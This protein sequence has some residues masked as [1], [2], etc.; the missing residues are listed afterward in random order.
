MPPLAEKSWRDITVLLWPAWDPRN[1]LRTCT[2][3]VSAKKRFDSTHA[4]AWPQTRR[5]LLQFRRHDDVD[6]VDRRSATMPNANTWIS[7]TGYC[8]STT[9]CTRVPVPIPTSIHVYV[10]VYVLVCTRVLMHGYFVPFAPKCWNPESNHCTSPKILKPTVT[11][12]IQNKGSHTI[13]G[14]PFHKC[15]DLS[16]QI[17]GI[18]Q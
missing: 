8:N 11:S 12:P 6:S 18:L 16:P 1:S 10:L 4:P 17:W 13:L 3:I 5:L 2:N 7:N 14:S 9:Q 15:G